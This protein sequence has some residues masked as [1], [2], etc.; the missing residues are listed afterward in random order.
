[1]ALTGTGVGS[2]APPTYCVDSLER[3]IVCG[4][5]PPT[6]V[7]PSGVLWEEIDDEQTDQLTNQTQRK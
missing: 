5:W 3:E 4:S 1:M 6:T 2:T 7:K